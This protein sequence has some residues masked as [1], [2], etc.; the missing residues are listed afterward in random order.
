MCL[1]PGLGELCS[2]CCLS[3]LTYY[4][5]G[6]VWAGDLE[7]VVPTTVWPFHGRKKRKAPR[8]VRKSAKPM[9][10]GDR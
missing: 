7:S 2:A 1:V 8:E 3:T 9:P 5:P 6:E 4:L 10:Y